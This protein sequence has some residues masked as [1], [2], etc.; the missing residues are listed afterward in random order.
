[1]IRSFYVLTKWVKGLPFT[2]TMEIAQE[3][4]PLYSHS[5]VSLE[6]S[7]CLTNKHL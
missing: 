7:F 1:M 6:D 4:A 3:V 2:P 5:T